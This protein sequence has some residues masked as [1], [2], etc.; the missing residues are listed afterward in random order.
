MEKSILQKNIKLKGVVD[1]QIGNIIC[2]KL[3]SENLSNSREYVFN[4]LALPLLTNNCLSGFDKKYHKLVIPK[5]P[6]KPGTHEHWPDKGAHIT[7][8]LENGYDGDIVNEDALKLQGRIVEVSFE[9]KPEFLEGAE[10]N[11]EGCGCV[12]YV[13][14][15]IDDVSK[16]I[17]QEL[18]SEVNLKP[19]PSNARTH[20]SIAGIASAEGG[21]IKELQ[22]LRKE[23]CHK[24]VS[25][26]IPSPHSILKKNSS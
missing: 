13:S 20:V 3:Y 9:S 24:N 23:W 18:R 1:V 12:F 10:K 8:A 5:T 17:I 22:K 6:F 21:S 26:G 19:L 4:E 16:K 14:L 11:D 7:V 15:N 2:I 25:N